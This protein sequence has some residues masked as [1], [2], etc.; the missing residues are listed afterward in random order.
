MA[1]KFVFSICSEDLIESDGKYIRFSGRPGYFFKIGNLK[2]G[3]E[4]KVFAVILDPAE[5]WTEER[6]VR[7]LNSTGV[8]WDSMKREDI[9]LPDFRN[10]ER[11]IA[12]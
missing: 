1:E 7:F 9:V 6:A 5:Q 10:G 4:N 2:D 11:R 12:I 8:K 3:G